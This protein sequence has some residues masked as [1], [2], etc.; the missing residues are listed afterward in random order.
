[1]SRFM[2]TTENKGSAVAEIGDRLATI[3]MG[4]K[5]GAVPFFGGQLGPHLTQC[6]RVR[7]LPP[8]EF[9]LDPCNRLAT[10]HQR[11]RQDREGR[12]RTDSIGRTKNGSKRLQN[13]EPRS[14][15]ACYRKLK[16]SV[17][18]RCMT[19]FLGTDSLHL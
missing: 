2:R 6:G 7:G 9:H 10:M 17:V 4:R 18:Q 14:K 11:H 3:D 1:M 12:Q 13:F 5:L 19:D 8:A 15:S 16:F